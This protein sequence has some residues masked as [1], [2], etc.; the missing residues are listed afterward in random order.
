MVY[1]HVKELYPDAVLE[2]IFDGFYKADIYI[3]SRNLVLEVNGPSHFNGRELFN[4]NKRALTKKR[5]FKLLGV[6][7]VD[8]SVIEYLKEN[9]YGTAAKFVK[10][11]LLHG[12]K[13]Q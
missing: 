8:I 6:K 11:S 12:T 10:S 1:Q 3:P 5:I 9:N 2:E 4:S 13:F 7:M